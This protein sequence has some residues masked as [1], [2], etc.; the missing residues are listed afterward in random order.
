MD[1]G[2]LLILMEFLAV[3]R[4]EALSLLQHFGGRVEEVLQSML[5]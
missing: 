5:S 2:A 3:S 1:E 4:Q